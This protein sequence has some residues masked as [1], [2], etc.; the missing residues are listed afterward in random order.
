[1]PGPGA[2]NY[3]LV[4]HEGLGGG[5]LPAA[6]EQHRAPRQYFAVLQKF[7]TRDLDPGDIRRLHIGDIHFHFLH[8]GAGRGLA[9][10][11]AHFHWSAPVIGFP[12][13]GVI[14]PLPGITLFTGDRAMEVILLFKADAGIHGVDAAIRV[15]PVDFDFGKSLGLGSTGG[16]RGRSQHRQKS[17]KGW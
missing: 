14:I 11:E 9:V 5:D 3:L 10:F 2:G 1:M 13:K 12:E 7:L 4:P 6:L 16:K 17:K 8:G 15:Q